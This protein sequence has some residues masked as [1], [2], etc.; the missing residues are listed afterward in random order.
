MTQIASAVCLGLL[1]GAIYWDVYEKPAEFARLDAQMAVTMSIFLVA[2]APFDVVMT[3]P[4]ERRIFSRE[5]KAGLY[6]SSALFFGRILA[7]FLQHIFVAFV[8]A[9]IVYFMVGLRMELSSWLLVNVGAVL[10]S[11]AMMQLCG[12]VCQTFDEANVLVLFVMMFSMMV[13]GAFVRVLP[14]WL[15]WSRNISI[16]SLLGDIGMYLE[17]KPE[18]AAAGALASVVSEDEAGQAVIKLCIFFIVCRL[19]TYVAIKFLHTSQTFQ[20]N[21]L[22]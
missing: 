21:L 12:A 7:D 14:S 8:Q 9:F 17:F 15:S 3:F 5:R 16:V 22:S 13:S 6:C 4:N 10:V 2:F 20:E 11:A 18:N 1:V 19:L